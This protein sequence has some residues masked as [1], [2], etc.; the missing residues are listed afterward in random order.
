MKLHD[1]R[2]NNLELIEA[3]LHSA[4]VI[5]EAEPLPVTLFIEMDQCYLEYKQQLYPIHLQSTSVVSASAAE[6][7]IRQN[8]FL[9]T[10]T[11][12]KDQ[13]LWLSGFPIDNNL[14]LHIDIGVT[15]SFSYLLADDAKTENSQIDLAILWLNEEFLIP[16]EDSESLAFSAFYPKQSSDIIHLIGKTHLL[17]IKQINDYWQISKLTQ[18]R[19]NHNFRLVTIQGNI[20]FKDAVSAKK[21]DNTAD[22]IALKE[23]TD[24]HG[25]YI[26]TWKQYSNAQWENATKRANQIG[27]LRYSKYEP[28]D[29]AGYWYIHIDDS[30]KL[31]E[32]ENKWN[33]FDRKK[34]EQIQLGLEI[35][36]W[37][38]N[39]I[40]V[41]E[42]GLTLDK[43]A[44]RAE[45]VRIEIKKQRILL[46]YAEKRDRRPPLDEDNKKGYLFLS[47]FSILV[48]RKRQ[49]EALTR[50]SNQ[51][52]PMY[53][54]RSLLQGLSM[55]SIGATKNFRKLK[56]KSVKTKNLFKGGRPT[57]KQQE[58][59]ELALN[60]SDLTIIIGPP[61]TGKTQVI[62]ALQQRIAEESKTSVQRS[63]LLTSYQHDA[64]DNVVERSD[65]LGLAGLRI[66]GKAKSDDEDHS[67][68]DTI[69]KW[70]V[71]I[72]E[73]IQQEIQSNNFIQLYRVL[74][75]SCLKLRL[76]NT[77]QKAES[78]I[79]IQQVLDRLEQDYKLSP[80]LDWKSWW[81]E[82]NTSSSLTTSS[83]IAHLYPLICSLRTTVNSFAD[84]GIQ[85]CRA[86]LAALELIQQN[87][88]MKILHADE[89]ELLHTFIQTDIHQL[90]QIDFSPLIT[91]KNI[92]IDR[93]L[94]DFRPQHLQ[95]L[96]NEEHCQKLDQLFKE[97]TNIAKK[98]KTL[99][100]LMILDKY[101]TSLSATT[102]VIK[103]AIAHYTAVLAATCQQAAGNAMQ[104]FKLINSK[105]IIFENVIVD[106][107][108][109]ATPLD[110]MIPM[111]MAK[112]RLVLVG[113]HRQLPHM[114]DDK[115]EKELSQQSEWKT[116][117]NEML[118]ESLFQRLVKDLQKLEDDKQQPKRVI[119][120]DTQFRMHPL[121]GQFISKNFYENHG[122][123][124][125][126]AGR[127]ETD[128]IHN[129]SG[130]ATSVCAFKNISNDPQQRPNKG[131]GWH[132][133]SEAKW[134]AQEAKRILDEKPELSV[135]VISFYR[136]QVDTLFNEMSDAKI[137]LTVGDKIAEPYRIIQTGKNKGDER[138]RIGTV[139]AFQGKEF[140]VVF[141]SLVRTLPETFQIDGLN[142]L[143]RD[144]KLTQTYGFL[145][146]D[147]RLNVALSRQ[148]SLL[149]VVGDRQL[150]QHN[151]TLEA[152]PA[153]PAFFAL[154]GGEHGQIL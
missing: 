8:N 115:I 79:E 89:K 18:K 23:H 82:F 76:G 31:I 98:S 40:E 127:P 146:I 142:D 72:Q 109:R 106:E 60:S 152:V 61:G 53:G 56:W 105:A 58:A 46:K 34:D 48:Q 21:V 45:I 119:M 39:Q 103:D 117:Q 95:S 80:S 66:G 71:P 13:Q 74:D 93:C 94:P 148:R 113:D 150:V 49:Q 9:W 22:K 124:P 78:K 35:P 96:L 17:E 12:Q 5:L 121:L 92:L 128:F 50:I 145:R 25:D 33:K 138:L 73:N 151:A 111:A 69:A 59:I 129:I 125:I 83:A 62:T 63:I 42:T 88:N 24:Q 54:L 140:D 70:A 130:Y 120:L 99:G 11:R 20:L 112:R 139:D 135:G 4:E 134:I 143:K 110:L 19:P 15:E 16:K 37:L 91:L 85:Q 147:N 10:L 84:D 26:E 136:G 30:D 102:G 141:V 153:L 38:D 97:I 27:F 104:D 123:P 51:E 28:A 87:L 77:E 126:K 75:E 100:Y 52:N 67:H 41:H 114:L 43:K 133:P 57:L 144:G 68:L 55:D 132:R 65:V 86:V 3:I 32:F 14:T 64:V 131:S 101:H 7:Y 36:E 81:R 118:K 1:F 29:R 107:A 116:I 154:C 90:E 149:I 6:A 44:W 137:G 2:S 47:I 108:A 122:L